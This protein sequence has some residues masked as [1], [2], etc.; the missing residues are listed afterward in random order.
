MNVKAMIKENNRLRER[1]T[2]D[3]RSFFEDMIIALRDSPVP[4]L[5]TEELL[6]QAA[7]DLLD[8]QAKGRTAKQL[9]GDHPEDY[10]RA[11]TEAAPPKRERSRAAQSAMIA[12]IALTWLFGIYA[13]GGL[14]MLYLNGSPGT[15]GEMSAFTVLLVGGGSVLLMEVLMK[16]LGNL[17][18][19]DKPEMIRINLRSIGLYLGI[20]AAVAIGGFFLSGLLPVFPL[21]PWVSLAL[22]A[23]GVLAR[24]IV[25][26]RG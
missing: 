22:F 24:K 13:A 11:E 1:M 8:A 23:V 25:F 19:A 12:W 2:P 9:F 3:N 15:F 17:S 10:F 4:P 5:R 16:W 26:G 7:K 14:L 20:A 21:S 6:L 18:D